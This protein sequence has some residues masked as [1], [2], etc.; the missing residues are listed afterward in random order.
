MH[1]IHVHQTELAVVKTIWKAFS[2]DRF[3]MNMGAAFDTGRE[4]ESGNGSVRV[5]VWYARGYVGVGGV[6]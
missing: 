4:E 6:M 1:D 2:Y 3:H 5:S